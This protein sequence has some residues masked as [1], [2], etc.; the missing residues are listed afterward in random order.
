MNYPKRILCWLPIL[1]L[2]AS[3]GL[4]G[5]P[6]AAGAPPATAQTGP[7]ARPIHLATATLTPAPL[8]TNAG[9]ESVEQHGRFSLRLPAG[10]HALEGIDGGVFVYHDTLPGFL[11]LYPAP[12]DPAATLTGLLNATAHTRRVETPLETEIGGLAFAGLFLET[13]GGDRLFLSAAEGWALVVQGP[14]EHW[15]SLAAGLNQAL[16][17]LTFEEATR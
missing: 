1:L 14:A 8:P 10:Y 15:P 5:S 4:P 3:C 6:P 11:V 9:P 16:T 2:A 17:S 12:G 13:S 7:T